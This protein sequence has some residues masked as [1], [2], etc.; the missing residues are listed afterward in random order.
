[1]IFFCAT[2][3]IVLMDLSVMVS[4]TVSRAVILRMTPSACASDLARAKA[5]PFTKVQR[6][7]AVSWSVPGGGEG[8]AVGTAGAG[9]PRD[10]W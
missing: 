3:A 9:G 5:R 1:M 10:V 2:A 4:A 7:A 8:C 6:L